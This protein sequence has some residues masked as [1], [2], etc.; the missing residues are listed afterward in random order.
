MEKSKL[1]AFR[2]DTE[3]L[4]KIDKLCDGKPYRNRSMV[5]SQI[6]K[7][8]LDCASPL[9]QARIIDTYDAYSAG[10]FLSFQQIDG[11]R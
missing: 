5:I 10:Y 7:A 11:K 4:S 3:S 1:I 8:V 9:T 6:L 2:I